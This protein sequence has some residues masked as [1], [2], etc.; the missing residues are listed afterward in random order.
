MH[1]TRSESA[2][3]THLDGA[4]A[5]RAGATR[6]FPRVAALLLIAV[7]LIGCG[8]QLIY[9]RVPWLAATYIGNQVSM[10]SSQSRALRAGLDD[11]FRWHRSN[12]LP[13]YADFLDRLARDLQTPTTF[14]AV[15]GA[16]IEIETFVRDSALRSAPAAARWSASLTTAQLDEF[17]ASLAEDD[18]EAREEYCNPD[19]VKNN[20]RREK[21]TIK[22]IEGW[23]GKLTSGQRALVRS[24]L[25]AIEPTGCAWVDARIKSR[26]EFRALVAKYRNSPELNEAMSRFLAEPGERWEPSYR[27]A[28]ERNRTTVINMLVDLHNTL[29]PKQRDRATA[30]LESYA[31]DFRELA[32]DGA[33]APSQAATN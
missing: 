10:D 9:N 15:D 6:R 11:F 17:L 3:P 33:R 19:V 4:C 32:A 25:A 24:R 18:D 5:R 23:T 26:G 22:A 16:R 29:E 27:S 20:E 31:R 28:Y 12:E 1:S 14:A 7:T 30:R 21:G 8:T 13:R 2:T